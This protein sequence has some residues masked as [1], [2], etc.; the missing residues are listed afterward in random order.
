MLVLSFLGLV[1]ADVKTDGAWVYWR[2][3][4]PI[5]AVLCL[6]LSWYLRRKGHSLSIVKV[7]HEVLHWVGLI[8]SVYLVTLF[9]EIGVMNRL[10]ASLVV[11]TMLALTTFL[12]GIYIE[13]T[14]VVVG[15][16]LGLFA[17][18]AAFA[19]AYL[20]TVMLPVLIFG[21]ILVTWV[22]HRLHNRPPPP[23][24]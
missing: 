23:S 7:Y 10:D 3:M 22:V 14:Y 5:F 8:V 21:I 4:V 16:I 11:I 18:G 19:E 6:W 12:A 20:Y 1:V 9:V 24:E 2:W 15:I 17:A 13:V